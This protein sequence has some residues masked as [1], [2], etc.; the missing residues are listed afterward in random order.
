MFFN[1]QTPLHEIHSEKLSTTS[2][3]RKLFVH[4]TEK[5]GELL[6]PT[7]R[8]SFSSGEWYAYKTRL[9]ADASRKGE[10]I[11]I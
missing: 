10:G 7:R 3:I 9:N 6:A 5:V 1:M 4:H 8:C 2:E 11:A